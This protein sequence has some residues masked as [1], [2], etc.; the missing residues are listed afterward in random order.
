MM[1]IDALIRPLEGASPCGEDMMFSAAFDEIRRARRFDDP[2]LSQG[3]W[4]TDLKEADWA[5]VVR[6]CS[7]LLATRT[8]DLRLAAW[9]AEALAKT[10]GVAGLG[11]GY[12]LL[13]RLCAAHWPDL[14][15]LAEE[16]DQE[17]RIGNL[18]W[19]L[20][21]SSRIIRELPL[22]NSPKGVFS[23]DD[24][25]TAR[26][27]AQAVERNPHE[28]EALLREARVTQAQFDAARED[29]P[30]TFFI[31]NLAAA[32][33]AQASL[34]Q[35]Q[36]VVDG[37]LD[38][39]GPAFGAARNALESLVDTL[40]RFA[41]RAAQANTDDPPAPAPDATPGLEP[42]AASA[43]REPSG[44]I[45]TRAQA[46]TQLRQV[47]AYFR[48]TEPH[49]PVAYLADKAAR[50]G[51]MPLHQWLRAVIS[52]DGALRHVEELLGIAGDAPG[53]SDDGR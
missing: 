10:R 11:E 5:G 35:L 6:R 15:P 17:A 27:L 34:A 40:G 33:T 43:S 18:D 36:R 45:H 39:E 51:E 19:L 42:L 41:G 24:L 47:A 7:E 4:V 26:H 12:L 49:S 44:P 3:E 46:L 52:D 9:L 13:A 53:G 48:R 2:S 8:K 20:S 38:A 1:D 21:Q 37:H 28:G 22:T 30:T 16:G 31:E 23:F 32:R 25:E 29:T 14:H 50:W